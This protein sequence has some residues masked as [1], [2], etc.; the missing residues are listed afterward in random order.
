M[1][2]AISIPDPIFESLERLA[3]RNG[4]SRSSLYVQALLDYLKA[5]RRKG[6]VQALNAIYHEE[7][8]T[9]NPILSKMQSTSLRK[10]DW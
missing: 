9:L 2:T 3:K 4:V 7:D 1:K 5:H 6:I 10:E 8:S